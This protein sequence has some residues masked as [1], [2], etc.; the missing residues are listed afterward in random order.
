V[1]EK[2]QL[3]SGEVSSDHGS[4]ATA[5]SGRGPSEDG[6]RPAADVGR[7]VGFDVDVP[8]TA[9][10]PPRY[11]SRCPLDLLPTAD[12]QQARDD[13]S[14][15]VTTTT[16]SGSYVM[17]LTENSSYGDWRQHVADIY[18]GVIV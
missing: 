1:R 13:V 3:A 16:T 9:V 10:R 12:Q 11:S 14:D 2:Q 4:A 6:V 15:D 8:A 7:F 18:Q 5:D 17:D